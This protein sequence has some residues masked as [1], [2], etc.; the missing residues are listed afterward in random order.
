MGDRHTQWLDRL[1]H[2]RLLAIGL[3]DTIKF[4]FLFGMHIP[5]NGNLI[6]I[7]TPK[8]SDIHTIACILPLNV[9]DGTDTT[10][11][12]YITLNFNQFVMY[13]FAHLALLGVQLQV[14]IPGR[15]RGVDH[16]LHVDSLRLE[17]GFP[18]GILLVDSDLEVLFHLHFV[19]TGSSSGTGR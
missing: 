14:L 13:N 3:E 8:R 9:Q 15:I 18:L 6:L 10:D 12:T 17:G 2:L 7:G 16:P 4:E 5:L 1:E 19:S 11:N